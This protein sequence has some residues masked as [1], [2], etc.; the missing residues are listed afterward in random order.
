MRVGTSTDS[1]P[2]SPSIR[3]IRKLG[4]YDQRSWIGRA[5]RLLLLAGLVVCTSLLPGC[6]PMA[7]DGG[8]PTEP[9]EG[10]DGPEVYEGR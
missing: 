5:A 3:P 8:H 1:T 9:V 6:L 4:R 7:P 2:S 10:D